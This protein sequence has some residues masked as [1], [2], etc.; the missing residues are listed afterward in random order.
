MSPKESAR[1]IRTFV[2]A[3]ERFYASRR[4]AEQMFG[5]GHKNPFP[6]LISAEYGVIDIEDL[7]VVSEAVLG[8]PKEVTEHPKYGGQ[9][10]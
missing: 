4:K 5:G 1:R 3:R 6:D 9:Y 8:K 10:L 2:S 7:K